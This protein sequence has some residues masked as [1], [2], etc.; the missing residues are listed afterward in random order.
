MRLFLD[1]RG[2][3]V[4]ISISEIRKAPYDFYAY[5]V[6]SIV[7]GKDESFRSSFPL[8]S[9]SR[10]TKGGGV[11]RIKNYRVGRF[12]NSSFPGLYLYKSRYAARSN[13]S[14]YNHEAIVKVI[15]PRG[16]VC[17]YSY[18]GGDAFTA[19]RIFVVG[20]TR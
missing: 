3:T 17:R 14:A 6:V 15:V 9:R 8:Y 5:K 11:G 1:K 18:F 19:E 12:A 16:T 4:C 20:K 13:W 7:R 10:Q 2:M